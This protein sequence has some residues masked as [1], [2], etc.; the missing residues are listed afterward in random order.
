MIA[1]EVATIREGNPT[2]A[3]Q[4]GGRG[5]RAAARQVSEHGAP[6]LI[7]AAKDGSLTVKPAAQLAKLPIE[8]QQKAIAAGIP[9]AK[10]VAAEVREYGADSVA[11]AG[12]PQ[13]A[14]TPARINYAPS[15]GMEVAPRAIAVL[16]RITDTDK[17]FEPAL[18]AIIAYCEKRLAQNT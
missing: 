12:Q 11:A 15:C 17:E 13:Q 1:Q 3:N 7:V 6:E 2:D 16:E 14:V 9:E 10:R 8:Q 18:R 5:H 4:Y